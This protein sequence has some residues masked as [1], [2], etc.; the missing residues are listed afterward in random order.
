[1]KKV[2]LMSHCVLNPFCELP[3]APEELRKPILD[4]SMDKGWGIVQLPCPELCYQALE[5]SSIYPKDDEAAPYEEY[6]R[7]LLKPLIKNLEEYKKHGISIVG[8][9]GIDTS[10]SCSIID[11][12]AIMMKVI[13]EELEKLGITDVFKADM[14]VNEE[15]DDEKFLADLQSW[16]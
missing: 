11:K 6:C 1:M 16:G 14:P 2:V 3:K 15:G 10:P 5:R 4:I 13:T 8:I 12:D 7:D 9:V